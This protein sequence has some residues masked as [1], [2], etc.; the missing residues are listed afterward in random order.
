[1]S[2]IASTPNATNATTTSAAS[3]T[4]KEEHAEKVAR[5]AKKAGGEFEAILVRQMLTSARVGGTSGYADMAVEAVANAVTAGG[6][7]GLGRQIA[8]AIGHLHAASPTGQAEKKS[9]QGP[10]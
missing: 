7:L 5:D 6:G 2:G 1:M 3:A 8:D 4:S 9:S 10:G